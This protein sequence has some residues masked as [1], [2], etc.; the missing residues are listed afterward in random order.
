M[1]K[2]HEGQANLSK[3]TMTSATRPASQYYS[4]DESRKQD[5]INSLLAL[6]T[7]FQRA[8]RTAA[9]SAAGHRQP[10]H[11]HVWCKYCKEV[12]VM[13]IGAGGCYCGRIGLVELVRTP[14]STEDDDLAC[15]QTEANR[16][17]VGKA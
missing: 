14:E 6:P 9:S 5:T 11:K 16:V 2:G 3:G 8:E 15:K 1:N 13:R 4:N 17:S 12:M 10:H 7:G